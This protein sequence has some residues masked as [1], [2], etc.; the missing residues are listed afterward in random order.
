[1][2]EN[3]ETLYAD[4]QKN[5]Y[6]PGYS[7]IVKRCPYCKMEHIHSGEQGHRAAHCFDKKTGKKIGITGYFVEVDWT[8]RKNMQQRKEYEDL[9]ERTANEYSNAL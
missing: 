1:M 8:K 7:L 9:L 3:T 6:S 4:L 2:N 5:R